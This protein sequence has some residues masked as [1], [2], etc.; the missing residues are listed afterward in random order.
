MQSNIGILEGLFKNKKIDLNRGDLFDKS[1][2][3]MPVNFDFDRVEGMMLGLAIGDSLGRSTEGMLPENRRARFGE[4]KDYLTSSYVDGPIGVPSDDTQLAFW[5][6]EQMINDR[7]FIPANVAGRFCRDRIFGIGSSVMRFLNNLKSGSPWFE[8]GPKSA[9]NGALMRIAPMVIPHLRTATSELWVDTAL[10]AMITHND[11]S[12]ISSYIS[13][14]NM[15]WQLLRMESPLEPYWWLK[16]YVDTARD[17]EIDEHYR[18]RGGAHM[19]FEGPVWRF[20][21]E[22]VPEAFD[23]GMSALEACNLWYSGAYLLETV[24]SV[25]LI[26]MKHGDNLE[27]ALIRA[28][29]DTK[30]NDTIGAI[31]GATVGALHGKGAIPE[32]WIKNHSGRTSFS[33]DGRIFELLSEAKSLWG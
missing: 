3:P 11:S 26:L 6:L 9:G 13:F 5:T 27:E 1:P 16:T 19:D 32:M 20:V 7:A 2:G 21:Q 12:S 28:I 30:D 15:L 17:L 29:N 33:D 23:K 8:A 24:P 4:I 10:S 22:K 25:I 31:V 18:Q 14:V